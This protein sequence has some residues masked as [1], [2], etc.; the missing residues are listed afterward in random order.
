[1][2]NGTIAFDTL[3]TS[4][5]ISGT[6]VSLDTDYLAYGSVKV[7]FLFDG[8]GT[9][10]IDDS[11]NVSSLDDDGTGQYGINY[12]NNFSTTN[13]CAAGDSTNGNASGTMRCIN[14]HTTNTTSAE[15]DTWAISSGSAANSD[16]SDNRGLIL[17][18]LA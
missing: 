16:P 15:M 9:V 7:W 17:G 4:G 12:T 13:Q 18:D 3:S 8:T 5:Q 6:A 2:A 1:M 14:F 10:A 11:F